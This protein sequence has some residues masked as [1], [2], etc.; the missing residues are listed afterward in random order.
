MGALI[1]LLR[2]DEA[3][4][5]ATT[6]SLPPVAAMA[7]PEADMSVPPVRMTLG[8][9]L[10]VAGVSAFVFFLV[11]SLS[12]IFKGMERVEVPGARELTLEA[13]DYTIYWESDS[14]FAAVASRPD[15]A[16]AVV[17]KDGGSGLPVSGAGLLSGRY[18]TMDNR[19]GSSIAAFTVEREGSYTVAV[20]AASG[21]TLPKGRL[22][23]SRRIGFLGVLKIVLGC[24]LIM[25]AGVGGGVLLLVR[26][27]S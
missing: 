9:L 26:K 15:L 8:I 27:G 10:I 22:T 25:G 13:G 19:I 14:R 11:T 20:A 3:R 23:V 5:G 2:Y 1:G 24:I 21:K 16:L 12:K 6:F 18:S 4:D 17:S 7:Y